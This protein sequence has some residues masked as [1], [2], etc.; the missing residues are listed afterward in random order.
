MQALRNLLGSGG[1]GVNLQNIGEQLRDLPQ[2]ILRRTNGNVDGPCHRHGR[3]S[4]NHRYHFSLHFEPRSEGGGLCQTGV[5]VATATTRSDG[6][7]PV[8]INCHWKRRIGTYLIEIPGIH[9]SMYH[10]SADDIGMDIVCIVEPQD[11]MYQGQAIGELGPF[12]LDPIT[13]MSLENLI[14]SAACR[15]PVRHYRDEDGTHPRDL[16]IHVTQEYVKVFHPGAERGSSEVMAPYSADYPKVVIHPLDTCK[17]RLELS[18]EPEKAYQFVALSRSSRDLIAL[19]IRCFHSRKYV[20]TSFVLSRLFQNPATPG[21]PLTSPME[22]VDFDIHGLGDRLGKELDRTVGQLEAVERVVRN[23]NEEKGQLQ[24]QLRETISSYTE[25]IEKLHMQLNVFKGGPT[26][27][28]QLQLHDARAVHSRLQLEMQELRHRL[29]EEQS[30]APKGSPAGGA[31]PA[32]GSGTQEEADTI[33]DEITQLQ[34]SIRAVA[35]DTAMHSQRDLARAEEL[36]RLRSD[37]DRLNSEKEGLEKCSQQAEIEK[38]DLIENFLYVKGRLDELQMA[39]GQTPAAP[40]EVEREVAQIQKTYSQVVDERNRLAVRVE[41]LDKDREKQK[42]QRESELERMMNA[43]ARLLEER[44]RL[45]KEKAR[46]SELYQRT[47]GAMGAV[48]QA[49]SA[50]V[51]AGDFAAMSSHENLAAVH[52]ALQNELREKTA[53]ISKREQEGESLRAR[54]RKL[55]MV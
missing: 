24:A 12:E 8:A 20:A 21:A 33:R 27:S 1:E 50:A 46:L 14:T 49:P 48:P 55:A 22:H 35:G 15:I 52:E 47:M 38:K 23:A 53:L 16:Q 11:N 17:F 31:G 19:L 6:G 29:D 34:T 3:V 13:R 25:A 4:G 41:A 26:A 42:Q 7:Q 36:R 2:H 43:N 30:R 39:W 45:A 37:V 54:L 10:T 5:L 51:A 44:D 9:G 28:L 40:P 18:E 32:E